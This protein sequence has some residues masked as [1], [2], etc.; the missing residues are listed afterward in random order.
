M[1]ERRRRLRWFVLLLWA[2]ITSLSVAHADPPRP[3][4]DDQGVPQVRFNFK[5]Q[6]WDQVLDYFARAT[7]MPVVR[8]VEPPK[9]TVD[10]LSPVAY[11]L[12]KAIETLNI[13]LQTR[14]VVLRL[15]DG[16]L[17]LDAIGEIKRENIPTFVENLPDD[18]TPD[19]IVTLIIPLLNATASRVAE[20][21][22]QMVAE[23]GVLAALPEQNSLL[24]VETAANVRRLRKIVDEL[25]REDVENAVEQIR[26]VHASAPD[27]VPVL[28]KLMSERV[29]RTVTKNKKPVQIE[30]DVMP[31]GF[32]L[33][34]DARTNSVI[35]RGTPRRLERVRSAIAMLDTPIV[36]SVR[37]MRTVPLDR[38]TVADARRSL[39][40]ICGRWRRCTAERA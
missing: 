19:T 13:L 1:I 10:Y 32:R 40:S 12:P 16:R 4:L 30:E 36:G 20:Q 38:L 33:T 23:Y 17:V 26:L 27:L 21:L 25:D 22:D 29:V 11:P 5:G 28:E 37:A 6:S 31:A 9:G 34:A 8:A 18:V 2:S 35:A 15:E 3:V 14:G 7:G 24:V 39:S